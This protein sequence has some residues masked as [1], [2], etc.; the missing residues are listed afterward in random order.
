MLLA[1]AG[2]RVLLVDKSTF[3]SDKLSTHYIQPPGVKLLEEWSLLDQVVATN[4]P[5]ITKFTVYSGDAVLFAPPMEG[6][7]YCPRRYLLDKILVDAAVAAGAELREGFKVDE[8]IMDGETVTGVAG[9]RGGGAQMR[10]SARYVVG[11]EGHHSI[12]A[13]A[14]H[15]PKYRE[16]EALTGGYYSY[17]SGV[18]MD[19]AE[20]YIS[21]RGGVLAFPTNDGLVC[22]AAGGARERFAD[23]RKD[24]EGTFFSILDA[25]P[26]FAAKVRAGKREE[27]WMGTADVPNFFRKPWGPGWALVGDA[28][29]M[30]DPT[31][32]F[33]I[34][35][36]FRDADLLAHALDD[37]LSGRARAEDALGAYQSQRDAIATPIYEMTLQ[38]AAGELA[39]PGAAP[40]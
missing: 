1:R 25:S 19:G 9:R 8:I 6:V 24:I 12:V 4:A 2:H 33:G 38:M 11:A 22:I 27:R 30:K 34:A 7:A 40:A 17:W 13:D 3:P 32:G 20:I 15:A 10:E 35:D 16:R 37:V 26:N 29:Y 21:D 14:V 23:Y 28:G 5:A 36:A 18:E 31:T 39:L